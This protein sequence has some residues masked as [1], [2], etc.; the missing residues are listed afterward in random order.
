M[1]LSI[2]PCTIQT[3]K[4]KIK[5]WK[6]SG[7]YILLSSLKLGRELKITNIQS[8]EADVKT[9]ALKLHTIWVHNSWK[10]PKC[11]ILSKKKK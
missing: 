7:H 1:N 2:N 4:E 11:I 5:L 10:M 8:P 9:G 3:G 6:A